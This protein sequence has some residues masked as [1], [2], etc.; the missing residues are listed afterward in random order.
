MKNNFIIF[1]TF[2]LIQFQIFKSYAVEFNLK[3]VQ[4][5]IDD[6][7][8]MDGMT[9]GS[10]EFL[11]FQVLQNLT[12]QLNNNKKSKSLVQDTLTVLDITD[13][14]EE[15]F[16]QVT[17]LQFPENFLV[18]SNLTVA[19]LT[20]ASFFLNSLNS[21]RLEKLKKLSDLSQGDSILSKINTQIVDELSLEPLKLIQQLEKM[22]KLDLVSLSTS[23]NEATSSILKNTEIVAN[24]LNEVTST[25]SNAIANA[26]AQVESATT[27]LSRAAGAAMAAAS[28]SLDQAAGEIANTISAGVSVDLDAAA[29][30]LGHDDFAAAVDAYN[31][32][33]GTN[34]TVDSAKEALGQ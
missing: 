26:T 6:I 17:K 30:G 32:Q 27:T 28:Y 8:V 7:K 5:K 13:F 16:P 20:N 4:E 10:P 12:T 11:M 33:Y 34:Y 23:V 2:I 29:Q 31:A 21:R 19:D 15:K 24:N 1:F 14:I 25:A 9:Q 3:D 22:P 18:G